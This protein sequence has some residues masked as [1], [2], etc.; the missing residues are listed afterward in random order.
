[1]RLQ[2]G[3]QHL[4]GTIEVVHPNAAGS[5]LYRADALPV[6]RLSEAT[7]CY[8]ERAEMLTVFRN[9]PF[10]RQRWVAE[11]MGNR[12][13]SPGLDAFDQCDLSYDSA[14]LCNMVCLLL[15]EAVHLDEWMQAIYRAAETWLRRSLI[16]TEWLERW[17]KIRIDA[18]GVRYRKYRDLSGITGKIDERMELPESSSSEGPPW[19]IRCASRREKLHDLLQAHCIYDEELLDQIH[20]MMMKYKSNVEVETGPIEG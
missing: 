5:M 15:D 9:H 8:T 11:S 12:A 20:E 13:Y 1:M 3:P 19:H 6:A 14:I 4:T 2:A 16:S 7:M 18:L 17:R 10:P